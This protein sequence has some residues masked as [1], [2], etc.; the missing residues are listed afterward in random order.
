MRR[1][2][3]AAAALL[4]AAGATAVLSFGSNDGRSMS[5][6]AS[7]MSAPV[8]CDRFP[9]ESSTAYSSTAKKIELPWRGD[10]PA[11]HTP[12]SHAW[13]SVALGN[14][15]AYMAA[16][17]GE[18]RAGQPKI[19]SKRLSMAPDA[20]W[21]ISPWMDFTSNGREPIHGLTRERSPDP[22]D[23]GPGAPGGLQVWAVGFY[24]AEGAYGLAQVFADPCDPK[25]PTAG[26]TF[27]DN[28]ASFKFLF[29]NGGK[30]AIPYLDGAPEIEAFID[31]PGGG[32]AR[33]IVR[34]LQ[35]DI[36]VR[37]ARAP[38]GWVFGTYV[39]KGPRK[40]DGLIDNL[41]PVGMMWGND[42]GVDAT[43]RDNFASLK[44]TKLNMALAGHVWRAAGQSWDERPWPGFQGRLNGPA[45]NLRSSCLSCHALAQWPRSRLGIVPSGPAYSLAKLND[46]A[47]RKQLR[48]DYMRNVVGGKLTLPE[49]AHPSASRGAAVPLDYSLQLEAGFSRICAA[50]ANGILTGKTPEVCKVKRPQGPVITSAS[51][52]APKNK[53]LFNLQPEAIGDEPPPRQ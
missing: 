17:L 11:S 3:F 22:G 53:T 38:T 52:P 37:D 26:W 31:A 28:S 29:T 13:E 46:A 44:E 21:W 48:D 25:V 12:S 51:C 20:Q 34:L 49:E 27:P 30:E 41:V 39:W 8:R 47:A 45:D 33:Q 43:P 18:I 24:N 4:C 2:V 1:L 50:C 19:I 23:V 7:V 6:A 16:V 9:A 42:P 32:R 36:A 5:A 35:V 10:L 15:E 40:G 14:W